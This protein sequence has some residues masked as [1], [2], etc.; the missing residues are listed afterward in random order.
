[1]SA[2]D[3]K[4]EK[5]LA[6][7]KR[8]NA[9]RKFLLS[10]KVLLALAFFVA[11]VWGANFFYNSNYF[12][13][14]NI[15]VEGNRYYSSDEIRKWADVATG[16]NIFEIDKKKI[17]DKLIDNLIRLK[18]ATMKKI[19]PDSVELIITERKPFVIAVFGGKYYVLDNEGIV[20][21]A[22]SGSIP[23]DYKNL[24]Q[25]KNGLKSHPEIGEKIARRNILSSADIYEALDLEI[26]NK[27][28]EAYISDGPEQDIIMVTTD[29]KKIIF[30]TSDKIADKNAILRQILD[31]VSKS[32][33]YYSVID[34]K[35]T[36][37][38]VI[39]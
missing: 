30:G 5:M 8:R 11:L 38:P 27:I 28:K 37:N 1:M 39:K 4:Y 29:A 15:S 18:S 24:I 23:G 17:E 26:K 32:G 7:R 9:K 3:K 34:L 36:G 14:K 21:E 22:L 10:L 20:L 13:I 19:F 2:I 12:K 16:E 35:N 6:G 33:I 25:V 31:N